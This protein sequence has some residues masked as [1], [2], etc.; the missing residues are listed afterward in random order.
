M[1]PLRL[2]ATI[3]AQPAPVP[4]ALQPTVV[5]TCVAPAPVPFQRVALFLSTHSGPTRTISSL[6]L[7]VAQVPELDCKLPISVSAVPRRVLLSF[8]A[9]LMLFML[10]AVS[11]PPLVKVSLTDPANAPQATPRTTPATHP[12]EKRFFIVLIFNLLYLI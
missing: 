11:V 3:P 4:S 9:L 5:R 12:T 8:T 7:F 10:V 2:C 1:T 6:A